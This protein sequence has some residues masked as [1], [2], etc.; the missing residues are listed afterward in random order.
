MTWSYRFNTGGWF[1]ILGLLACY[2]WSTTSLYTVIASTNPRFVQ[3]MPPGVNHT[4]NQ[5]QKTWNHRERHDLLIG[6]RFDVN[7]V[8]TFSE[9]FPFSRWNVLRLERAVKDVDSMTGLESLPV[10]D[11]Y[12]RSALASRYP[13]PPSLLSVYYMT[14]PSKR[15]PLLD[16][17]NPDQ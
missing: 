9:G 17:R 3:I 1:R 16:W 8:E 14:W 6:G 12:A 2:R 7:P 13:I 15:F 10:Q 4:V 5:V 11:W